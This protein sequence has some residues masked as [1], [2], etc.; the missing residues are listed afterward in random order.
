[1]AKKR[2]PPKLNEINGKVI[3]AFSASPWR[4]NHKELVSV[5]VN[6]DP[7]YDLSVQDALKLANTLQEPYAT[8]LREAAGQARSL[9]MLSD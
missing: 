8:E 6:D 4:W 1:M 9:G 7:P 5:R 3:V 2:T